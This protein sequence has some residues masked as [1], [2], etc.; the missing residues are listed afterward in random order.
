MMSRT[1]EQQEGMAG[2][3]AGAQD[4][5]LGMMGRTP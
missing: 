3:E 1:Y 2:P 5:L 4:Q